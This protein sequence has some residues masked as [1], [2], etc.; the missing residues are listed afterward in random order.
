MS[1][2][3]SLLLFPLLLVTLFACSEEPQ[4]PIRLGTN[5]WPGYEPLYLAQHLDLIKPEEF[6]LIEYPSASEVIRAFRN[7]S[8]EAAALTLDEAL[9]LQQD[10]IPVSVVLVTDI[11]DGGDVI[12]ARKEIGDMTALKGKRVAVESSALG[13][14]VIARAL[15]LH[16]M[17]LNDIEIRHL[18]VSAHQ[19]AYS[20]GKV[21]AAVTFE[22]VRTQLLNLGAHEIF[23]SKEVPGEI[24]DVLVV[25]NSLLQQTKRLKALIDGWFTA[26]DHLKSQPQS[27]AAIIASRHKITAAEVLGSFEGLQLPDRRENQRLLAG[28]GP[29]FTTVQRLSDSM[30]ENGLLRGE[31][32]ASAL[33]HDG[34]VN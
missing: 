34:M 20:S 11:S 9:L 14:Y 25:H 21:D 33:I 24:V 30:Q 27:A 3:R 23:T 32:S 17:S 1:R 2:I 10:D 22:P 13:G 19:A 5:I 28:D 7:R 18:E 6:R 4:Q 29:L 15:E 26:L 31:I 16:G 12:M 8:L